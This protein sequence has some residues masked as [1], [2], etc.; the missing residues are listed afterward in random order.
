[1]KICQ[2]KDDTL[3]KAVEQRLLGVLDLVSAKER[4]RIKCRR[5][6]ERDKT[7]DTLPAD[8]TLSKNEV[9]NIMCQKVENIENSY[10]LQ[11]FSNGMKEYGVEA[12][13]NRTIKS[14]LQKMYGESISFLEKP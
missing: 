1:M 7:K 4:Y 14:K 6:F 9:F 10:T 11:D 13:D 3:S 5:D 8:N 2:N 12:F